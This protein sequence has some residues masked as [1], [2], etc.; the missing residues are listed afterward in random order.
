[1]TEMHNLYKYRISTCLI[2]TELTNEGTSKAIKLVQRVF[3]DLN[4]YKK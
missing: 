4:I 2:F 1:M 3:E